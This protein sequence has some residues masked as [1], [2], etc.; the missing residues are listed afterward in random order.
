[1]HVKIDIPYYMLVIFPFAYLYISKDGHGATEESCVPES[2]YIANTS[3]LSTILVEIYW[4]FESTVDIVD[5][6][7]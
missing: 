6:C 1:M 2:C 3:V 5:R 7:L 4:T